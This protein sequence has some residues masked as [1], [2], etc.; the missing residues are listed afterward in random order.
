MLSSHAAVISSPASR[1]DSSK[2]MI[3]N[4]FLEQIRIGHT[5]HLQIALRDLS[6]LENQHALSAIMT[7]CMNNLE[8]L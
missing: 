7:T 5:R 8:T 3:A 6:T 1:H 4:L 2:K